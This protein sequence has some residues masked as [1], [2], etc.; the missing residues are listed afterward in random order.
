M[1]AVIVFCL[2]IANAFCIDDK[3]IYVNK[4]VRMLEIV[5]QIDLLFPY[6]LLY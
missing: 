3:N 2:G 4:Y 6:A 1:F 5:G